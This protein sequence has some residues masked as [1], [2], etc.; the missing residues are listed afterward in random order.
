VNLAAGV[1]QMKGLIGYASGRITFLNPEGLE[2]S[3][4]ECYRIL[5]RTINLLFRPEDR[6]ASD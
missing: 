4:C 3:S 1:L 5:S 6:S 2:V